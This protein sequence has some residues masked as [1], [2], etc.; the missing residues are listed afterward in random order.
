MNFGSFDLRKLR[1]RDIALAMIVLSVVA[2]VLWWFFLYQ[3]TQDRIAELQ[4]EIARLDTTIADGERARANLPQLRQTVA[5]LEADRAEFLR[6]LPLESEIGDFIEQI[7]VTASESDVEVLSFNQGN[8]SENIQDVRPISFTVNNRGD[9]GAT[10][11]FLQQ[12]ET[13]QR[14]TKIS[15][16]GLSSSDAE[17]ASPDDPLLNSN[18]TFTI[19]VYTGTDPGEQP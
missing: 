2:A 13:L 9:F 1:Q 15:Q 10:M 16:V 11:G 6:Q 19:Y 5:E 3:P 12:L 7:R 17:D 14:F 4:A 18:Y 8:A